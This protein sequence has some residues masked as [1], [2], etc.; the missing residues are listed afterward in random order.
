MIPVEV[1]LKDF[2]VYL[3]EAKW[4]LRSILC[5]NI[6]SALL[7][8]ISAIFTKYLVIGVVFSLLV[9]YN[10]LVMILPNWVNARQSY[11]EAK[12]FYKVLINSEPCGFKPLYLEG[13]YN[14]KD[15]TYDFT[16]KPCSYY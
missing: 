16:I 1:R 13:S 12:K 11:R 14:R 7:V 9:L 5:I 2:D 10:I 3:K 8:V 15:L 6:S 4:F